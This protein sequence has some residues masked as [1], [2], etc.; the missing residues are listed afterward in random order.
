M[1]RGGRSVARPRHYNDL[2]ESSKRIY[3]YDWRDYE[4]RVRAAGMP[5]F[6]PGDF[7]ESYLE[8][9]ATISVTRAKRRMAAIAYRFALEGLPDP[10]A[11]LPIRRALY[12]LSDAP[13]LTP[14]RLLGL[15]PPAARPYAQYYVDGQYAPSTLR[16]RQAFAGSW[17][18][19]AQ[20]R[21]IDPQHPCVDDLIAHLHE[22]DA[23]GYSA[24]CNRVNGLSHYFTDRKLPDLTRAPEVELLLEGRRRRP[25]QPKPPIFLPDLRRIVAQFGNGALDRRDH[26][27]AL[28]AFFG[29]LNGVRQSSLDVEDFEELHDGGMKVRVGDISFYIDGYPEDSNLDLVQIFRRYLQTVPWRSGRLFR[30]MGLRHEYLE[31]CSPVSLTMGLRRAAELSGITGGHIPERLA[32]GLRIHMLQCFGTIATAKRLGVHPNSLA[33][34]TP[35]V[36]AEQQQLRDSSRF[37]RTGSTTPRRGKRSSD[38]RQR[39]RKRKPK[40]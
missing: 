5:L 38:A 10:T 21:G 18:V 28:L 15:I 11:D 40:T 27:V 31:R 13:R 36:R 39:R 1:P 35:S 16:L 23:C 6:A 30:A 32:A 37:G 14:D 24:M 12:H 7:L 2:A 33:Q 17:E 4:D 34:K 22:Y 8:R 25:G 26:L 19:W 9:E 3:G 29:P 20:L